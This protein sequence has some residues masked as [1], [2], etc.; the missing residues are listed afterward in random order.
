MSNP[1]SRFLLLFVRSET[2]SVSS[3]VLGKS[4]KIGEPGTCESFSIALAGLRPRLQ[5]ALQQAPSSVRSVDIAT[6]GQKDGPGGVGR[7]SHNFIDH[8]SSSNK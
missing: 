8:S 1:V 7:L 4:V 2:R 3:F 5:M 6:L